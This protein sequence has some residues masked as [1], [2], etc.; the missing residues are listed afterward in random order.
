VDVLDEQEEV[1][2]VADKPIEIG[3]VKGVSIGIG[4]SIYCSSI[5]G[6]TFLSA[7]FHSKFSLPTVSFHLGADVCTIDVR[8]RSPRK[9]FWPLHGRCE[10]RGVCGPHVNVKY[11]SAEELTAAG[12]RKTVER[13]GTLRAIEIETLELQPC[14]ER[15]CSAPARSG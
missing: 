5:P 14:G 13:S 6:N 3:A 11:G 1:I 10:R 15:M 12:V 8:G 4:A 9:K 2:H 7:V